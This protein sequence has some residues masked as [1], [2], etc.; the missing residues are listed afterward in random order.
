MRPYV[1][2][3]A[4]VQSRFD[5]KYLFY[6]EISADLAKVK[7]Y[8]FVQ[9]KYFWP[10]SARSNVLCLMPGYSYGAIETTVKFAI[11]IMECYK[12]WISSLCNFATFDGPDAKIFETC[13]QSSSETVTVYSVEQIAAA[14]G[15]LPSTYDGT[16][17]DTNGCITII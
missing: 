8:P 12:T 2:A 1:I 16:G 4:F 7:A 13:D 15:F 14:E 17:T 6:N 3:Q 9:L 5:V 10:G 11:K